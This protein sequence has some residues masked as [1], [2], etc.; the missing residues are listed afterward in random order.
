MD[1][2]GESDKKSQA[3][4]M[5]KPK[6]ANANEGLLIRYIVEKLIRKCGFERVDGETPLPHRPLVNSVRKYLQRRERK[7]K[8]KQEQAQKKSEDK[9]SVDVDMEEKGAREL[10]MPSGIRVD[11]ELVDSDDEEDVTPKSAGKGKES[12]RSRRDKKEEKEFVI[13]EDDDALDLLDSSETSERLRM[14]GHFTK[15]KV[16]KKKDAP[17]EF[18]SE[19]KLI[20][21][22]DE[23]KESGSSVTPGNRSFFVSF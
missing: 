23:K 21:P 2:V 1:D 19:G 11:R 22:M 4:K 3:H 9:H 15:E 16:I 8:E 5:E 14:Q 20:I 13:R 10:K 6:Y 18:N 17:F 12:K 7:Q